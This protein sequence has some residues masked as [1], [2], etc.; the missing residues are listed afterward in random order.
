MKRAAVLPAAISIALATLTP[1]V[2]RASH[3]GPSAA[4][5]RPAR[6][7]A[8][9]VRH[10]HT[11]L[12]SALTAS[13]GRGGE[14][15]GT[16]VAVS[17][18]TVAVGAPARASHG[19]KNQGAVYVFTRVGTGWKH[20]RQRAV[21]VA[22]NGRTDDYL[23]ASV[24]ISGNTIVA[25]APYRTVA[26]DKFQGAA[27]VWTKPN[28]GWANAKHPAASLVAHDATTRDQ[29]GLSV[30]ISGG[31]I[32]VGAPGHVVGFHQQQ[33]AAYTFSKGSGWSGTTSDTGELVATL[34]DAGDQ[35][36]TTVGIDGKTIVAGAPY[37]AV[38]LH[39]NQ[40]AAYVF[41]KAAN[42]WRHTTDRATLT[43]RNGAKSNFFGD[44]IAVRGATVAVDAPYRKV[45][46][47][48]HQGA[49]YIF[50]KPGSGW[51]GPQTQ[52]ATLTVK[53]GAD[54]AYSG[55]GLAITGRTVVVSGYGLATLFNRPTGGWSGGQH[56]AAT[57]VG[58]SPG[59]F[60]GKSVYADG[61]TIVA[62]AP[63]VFVGKRPT[64][65]GA[66]YVY[67]K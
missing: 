20:F 11:V 26:G 5:T 15:F 54:N 55:L 30:G 45:S 8:A 21:L 60:I 24:A 19:H 13:D 61:K 1:A 37:H 7:V 67:R 17:G 34:G 2:A 4:A 29:F 36:G 31:T 62:G 53:P 3:Q 28:G 27:F 23:G 32:V 12:K 6:H 35:L 25:G 22:G 58:Q 39:P 65:A 64:Q 49:A 33:G 47:H 63:T 56:Q 48:K 18:N 52:Q 46:G 44:G 66:A 57:L 43:Q 16:S 10:R 42:G 38:G 41:V 40:G 50:T 14:L 9:T 59:D 51:S